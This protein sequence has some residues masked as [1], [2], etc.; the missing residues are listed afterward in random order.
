MHRV[1]WASWAKT[2]ASVEMEEAKWHASVR[3]RLKGNSVENAKIGLA[4]SAPRSA[5]QKSSILEYCVTVG[6]RHKKAVSK[7][8][9]LLTLCKAA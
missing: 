3:E 4:G 2:T 9:V 7:S 5:T 6:K 8:A 1:D